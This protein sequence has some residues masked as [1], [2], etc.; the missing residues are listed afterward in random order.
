MS[1]S[2]R[3]M[4]RACRAPL[5]ASR[6]AQSGG[7][8]HLAMMGWG[9]LSE[10]CENRNSA[11]GVRLAGKAFQKRSRE[12]RFANTRPHRE[13]HHLA[14]PFFALVSVAAA[15]G[16]FSRPTSAVSQ[17]RAVHRTGSIELARITAHARTGPASLWSLAPGRLEQRIAQKFRVPSAITSASGS[18]IP[19]RRAA[20]FGVSPTIPRPSRFLDP[21]G[22]QPQ[23]TGGNANTGLQRRMRPEFAKLPNGS[24]PARTARSASS[25]WACGYPK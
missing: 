11:T 20:R 1:K 13:K 2:A 24:S 23:Q 3:A 8:F 10:C 7:T 12:P 5:A 17:L 25:S 21:S 9:A 19:C 22:R 4:H 16:F 15:I 14:T 6:R 18:A